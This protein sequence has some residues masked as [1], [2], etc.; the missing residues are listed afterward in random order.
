MVTITIPC[1]WALN[2]ETREME[3]TESEEVKLYRFSELSDKA[4]DAAFAEW[5]EDSYNSYDFF[6]QE[7]R[8]SINKFAEEFELTIKDWDTGY[9]YVRW[10]FKHDAA[11]CFYTTPTTTMNC[12]DFKHPWDWDEGFT[13]A[14]LYGWLMNNKSHMIS[15]PKR[16]YKKRVPKE[17]RV[18]KWSLR[19]RRPWP[20]YRDSRVVFEASDCPFTGCCTDCGLLE[21]FKK[22]C[23]P[24]PHEEKLAWSNTS[25]KDL[26]DDALQQW[27]QDFRDEIEYCHSREYFNVEAGNY[28]GERW[29]DEEGKR[30]EEYDDKIK[31]R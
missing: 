26:I 14:R 5:E 4:K 9:G 25:L 22:F 19:T 6:D 7:F 23:S 27:M 8:D 30:M 21:P 17:Q 31:D 10:A 20:E 24:I 29:Y 2:Q 15:S 1:A 12:D 3:V 28:D 11:T 13:G 18:E 16:R